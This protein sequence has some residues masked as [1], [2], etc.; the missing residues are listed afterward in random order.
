MFHKSNF[1]SRV[2]VDLF[3][4]VLLSYLWEYRHKSYISDLL[5][6]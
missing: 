6:C 1:R 2:E 3:N 4:A 5:G